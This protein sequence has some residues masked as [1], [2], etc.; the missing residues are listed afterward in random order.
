MPDT[1]DLHPVIDFLSGLHSNNNKPWFEKNRPAY[2]RART[3]F[4]I[5]VNDIIHVFRASDGLQGLA[6]SDC[7]P[8]IYRDIRFSKDKSPYKTNM[9]AM[10][11]PGGWKPTRLGYY[12][13][14]EP[15]GQSLV[16][17]GLYDPTPDQLERFRRAIDR[18]AAGFKKV[19]GA[20]SFVE[21]FGA[22]EGERLKTA[23]KGYDRYHQEI[24]LLQLKQITA[25]HRFPD[26]EVFARDFEDQLVHLC[27]AM[28]PF[29]SYLNSLLY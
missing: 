13:S 22:L 17:G 28:K 9:S 26:R 5:F 3:T 19:T 6:A 21:P 20:G 2:E 10:I 8:R 23:P 15:D 4:K 29:L 12:V 7:I 24:A 11:A 25:I 16:A 14:L 18:D 1:P 27:K